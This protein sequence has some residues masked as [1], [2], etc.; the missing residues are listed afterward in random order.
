MHLFLIRCILSQ[1][2]AVHSVVFNTP[3]W[4]DGSQNCHTTKPTVEEVVDVHDVLPGCLSVV[5]EAL[6]FDDTDV[7]C[8]SCA[9]DGDEVLNPDEV[10]V[11]RLG[12]CT[13]GVEVLNRDDVD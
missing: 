12:C 4:C 2:C 5:V 7:Q 13:D 6:F 8:L 10:E 9:T 3:S 11:V 1:E